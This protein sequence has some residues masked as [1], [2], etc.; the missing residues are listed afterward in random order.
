MTTSSLLRRARRAAGLTQA[1][2]AER[3]GISQPE[4]AR[5]ESSRA[6]PTVRTLED[7]IAATGHELVLDAKPDR[8]GIDEAQILEN[9]KL[10]PAE[11]LDR[12]VAAQRNLDELIRA[13][14]F[15]DG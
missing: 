14:R 9:L 3:L 6:N 4:V 1:D 15:R 12:L 7:A 5:L 13:A 11:R 10:T 8:S 2:L